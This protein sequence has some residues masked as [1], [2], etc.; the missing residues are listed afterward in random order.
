MNLSAFKAALNT[1]DQVTFSL[2]GGELV[3]PHFHVTEVGLVQRHYVDCGGTERKES[4]IVFQLFTATD[5]DH[6]L[7]AEKLKGI[8]ELSEK[9]LALADAEIHIEYQGRT[10]EKYGVEFAN[11]QFNLQ[12]TLTDCL[13]KDKCGIPEVKP[14]LRLSAVAMATKDCTP[15]SGCC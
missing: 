12:T 1:L 8:L 10:I 6:R 9:K 11:G 7:S 15:G 5:Y 3:P 13:A 14:K 4:S 2:P